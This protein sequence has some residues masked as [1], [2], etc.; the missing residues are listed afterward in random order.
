MEEFDHNPA[1]STD[2]YEAEW[3]SIVDDAVAEPTTG[4]HD[5]LDIVERMLRDYD[6]PLA[7]TR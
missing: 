3:A 7:A 4:L 6:L 5:L 1:P 2:E